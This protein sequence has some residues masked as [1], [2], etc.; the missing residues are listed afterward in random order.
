[1]ND[2]TWNPVIDIHTHLSSRAQSVNG[3]GTGEKMKVR[4]HPGNSFAVMDKKNSPMMVKPQGRLSF[5]PGIRLT[6]C[7]RG[8]DLPTTL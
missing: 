1:V 3:A 8:F 2:E 6:S 5:T 7:L 4:C